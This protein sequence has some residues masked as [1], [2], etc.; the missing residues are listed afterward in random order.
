MVMYE[1]EP[2]GQFKKDVKSCQKGNYDMSL[3]ADAL[4]ILK[5]TGTLPIVPYKTHKLTG[6]KNDVWDAHIKPDWI[7]L[8]GVQKSI[9]PS[10]KAL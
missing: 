10:L 6:Q 8:F 9:I 5:S 2:S 4:T 3:L 7:L 1:L